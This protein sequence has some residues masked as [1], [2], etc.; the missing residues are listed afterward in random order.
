MGDTNFE[1]QLSEMLPPPTPPDSILFIG[2]PMLQKI[3]LNY[4]YI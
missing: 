2:R 4:Y 3:E 1:S